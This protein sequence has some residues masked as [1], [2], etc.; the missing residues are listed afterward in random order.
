VLSNGFSTDRELLGSPT[1]SSQE[2]HPNPCQTTQNTSNILYQNINF[3]THFYEIHDPNTRHS[4]DFSQDRSIGNFVRNFKTTMVQTFDTDFYITLLLEA[5]HNFT[6]TSH[7]ISHRISHRI[8]HRI[9]QDLREDSNGASTARRR[10]VGGNLLFNVAFSY[11]MAKKQDMSLV[12]VA[13][14]VVFALFLLYVFFSMSTESFGDEGKICGGR[15]DKVRERCKPGST[16][17]KRCKR[18]CKKLIKHHENDST[19]M[20]F[21]DNNCG[22]FK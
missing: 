16:G 13:L 22:E 10:T 3:I 9:S 11:T 17:S 2:R 18:A 15:G 21:Y 6:Q 12:Y 14:A 1:V 7:G 8:L 4:T 19:C 20:F 5:C